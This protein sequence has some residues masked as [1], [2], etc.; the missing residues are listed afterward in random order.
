MQFDLSVVICTYNP[1]LEILEE[2]LAALRCQQPLKLQRRWELLVI[3]NASTPP[4]GDRLDLSWHEHARVIRE[5]KLGVTHARLRGYHEAK[6]ELL[7]FVDDDNILAPNYLELIEAAFEADPSL[8]AAGGKILPRYQTEP[9]A[10]FAA[11]KLDLACRDLG[12][13][14]LYVSWKDTDPSSRDFPASAPVGAGMG[15][16]RAAFATYVEATDSNPVRKLLDRRGKDL[17][18]AGDNDIVLTALAHGWRTAYLPELSIHHIIPSVRVSFA[19]LARYAFSTN[20]SW[21]QVL[22][23]HGLCPWPPL[24]RWDANLRKMAKFVLIGAWMSPVRYLRWR[25]ACGLLDGRAS[26]H[27]KNG[28]F[29]GSSLRQ[30]PNQAG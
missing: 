30:V 24:Q 17:T 4:L 22:A 28:E 1:A 10:W 6:S 7:V 5:E 27:P 19:Y 12:D 15:I 21:L 9:P 8:G 20:K 14:P 29:S 25:C 18:S 26:L 11:T 13:E 2:T 16:R 23:V 3:D